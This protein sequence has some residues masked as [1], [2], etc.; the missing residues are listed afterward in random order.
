MGSIQGTVRQSCEKIA[1]WLDKRCVKKSCTTDKVNQFAIGMILQVSMVVGCATSFVF[2]VVIH[3][4][5]ALGAIPS[6]VIGFF[7][8]YL[9]EKNAST[10]SSFFSRREEFI[11]G[12]PVGLRNNSYTNCWLNACLQ[13]L[14]IFPKFCKQMREVTDT[15]GAKFLLR[16]FL[17]QYQQMQS[18]ATD[19]SFIDMAEVNE[20]LEAEMRVRQLGEA[21][22]G[23]G[24]VDATVF[25]D[26]FLSRPHL[27]QFD[28]ITTFDDTYTESRY[29]YL[30]QN[31]PQASVETLQEHARRSHGSGKTE[32]MIDLMFNENVNLPAQEHF[33]RF[34][35]GDSFNRSSSSTANAKIRR[36]LWQIPEVLVCKVVRY[37]WEMENQSV[38]REPIKGINEPIILFKDNVKNCR[39]DTRYLCTAFIVHS[40]GFSGG[41]YVAYVK[42]EG[43]WWC[44]NDT[45]ISPVTHQEAEEQM[46]EC[47]VFFAAKQEA[48]SVSGTT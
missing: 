28:T 48:N 27:Y 46:Q 38:I 24:H 26:W 16:D 8:F 21:S 37:R 1:H 6:I 42:K 20:A 7:G 36:I 44:C 40:G 5:I 25:L 34:F 23:L 2:A 15:T 13:C 11:K 18:S 47:Y 17:N 10:H 19:H 33:N 31:N 14:V 29:H 39:Q 3:P 4:A 45:T 22:A 12:Q 35:N 30:A 41:H 9:T 43:R 32:V